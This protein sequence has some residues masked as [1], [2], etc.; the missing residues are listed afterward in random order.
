M[1]DLLISRP[2]RAGRLTYPYRQHPTC[3]IFAR[4]L[5]EWR[6][7]IRSGL[8]IRRSQ[9]LTSSSLVSGTT[10]NHS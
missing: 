9:G 4:N 6:N 2:I 5:P 10:Q 3:G 7:G 8:K 1:P